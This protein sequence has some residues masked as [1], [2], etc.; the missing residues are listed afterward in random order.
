M[1]TTPQLA[2]YLHDY[3]IVN[4]SVSKHIL[5]QLLRACGGSI[6]MDA[7]AFMEDLRG[8]NIERVDYQDPWRIVIKLEDFS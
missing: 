4:V 2:L 1:G 5:V 6:S 8:V 7:S 3:D